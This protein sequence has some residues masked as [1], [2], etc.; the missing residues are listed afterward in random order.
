ME[1]PKAEQPVHKDATNEPPPVI[2]VTLSLSGLEHILAELS[3]LRDATK[4]HSALV[5]W[6]EQASLV[7]AEVADGNTGAKL[8]CE[9]RRGLNEY[10][11]LDA[12]A[13]GVTT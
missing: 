6:A 8:R 5:D 12:A 9:A 7:L 1:E 11:A 13:K 10:Y 3:R 2:K 4:Q